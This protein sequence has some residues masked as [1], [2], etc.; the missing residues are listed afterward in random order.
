MPQ[1]TPAPGAPARSS[2]ARRDILATL[3]GDRATGQ[4]LATGPEPALGLTAPELAASL[5][6]HVSTV[7]FHLDHLLAAGLVHEGP[8][9]ES[10]RGRRGRPA[11][12]YVAG[13]AGRAG[14]DQSYRLLAELLADSCTSAAGPPGPL[15]PEEAG[16]RWAERHVR[17]VAPPASRAPSVGEW[18]GRVGVV[19]DHLRHWGYD[20]EVAMT[21]GGRLV[22][23]DLAHC[24]FL[25]LARSREAVVCGIHRGLVRGALEAAGEREARVV[26]EPFVGEHL[27]R[28]LLQRTA[29]FEEAS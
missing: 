7:R 1:L 21:D 8:P 20:P 23:L 25:E 10:E 4:D 3:S 2:G 22:R 29:P 28:V 11:K 19:V 26:L 15:A 24:P 18:M 6:L 16:R 5:G 17:P 9:A 14:D 27:C 13:R 12:R